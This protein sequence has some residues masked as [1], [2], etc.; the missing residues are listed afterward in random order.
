M[1]QKGFHSIVLQHMLCSTVLWVNKKRKSLIAKVDEIWKNNS[2]LVRHIWLYNNRCSKPSHMWGL[3]VLLSIMGTFIHLI[4]KKLFVVVVLSS[5]LG[6]RQAQREVVKIFFFDFAYWAWSTPWGHVLSPIT[7]CRNPALS[8]AIRYS[9]F[10]KVK[11]TSNFEF[12][13]GNLFS[14][15]W[16]LM[17][18]FG[19]IRWF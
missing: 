10:Q 7:F 16:H 8:W 1:I 11:F 6:A 9:V 3:T 14:T 4:N 18:K 2:L 12:V 5:E 17:V 13:C 15:F 19:Y